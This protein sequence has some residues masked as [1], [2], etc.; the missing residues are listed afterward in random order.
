MSVDLVTKEI[1]AS[2]LPH[3]LKDDLAEDHGLLAYKYVKIGHR[4]DDAVL[5]RRERNCVYLW[6]PS[7]KRCGV[8]LVSG[9]YISYST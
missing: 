5:K 1:S 6:L 9:L 4:C 7:L 3:F 2:L 8:L